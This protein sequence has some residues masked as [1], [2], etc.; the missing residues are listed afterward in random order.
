MLVENRVGNVLFRLDRRN[1]SFHVKQFFRGLSMEHCKPKLPSA[2]VV[3]EG[4]CKGGGQLGAVAEQA[5]QLLKRRLRLQ[6][7][8]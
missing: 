6:G 7:H 2:E 8:N 5:V 3:G 4:S 1:Q